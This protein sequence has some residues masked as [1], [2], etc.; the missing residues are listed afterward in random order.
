MEPFA[1]RRAEAMAATPQSTG[2]LAGKVAIVTGAASGIGLATLERFIAEGARVVFCDL[3]P[4]QGREMEG[5]IGAVASRLHHRRREEGG[6][7]D[8]YAIAARLGPATHFMPS[9][10]ADPKSLAA[11][12]DYAR[13][14]FGG[15][16]ILVNNAGVGGF[17]GSVEACSEEIFDRT[18]AVNLRA[19]WMAMKLAFPLLR[20]R[21]GGSIITTSSISALLGMPGQGAYGASK[22]AI[23]QL[24]RV[25]AMEGAKDFIRVNAVCPG[26]ILTPIIYDTPLLDRATDKALV[27]DALAKA[28]PIPR[29]GL[30]EDI[31][32]AIL[33]LASDES[34][35]VTG[36]AIA[37]DGGL[38]V[39]FGSQYR[40]K[41]AKKE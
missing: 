27:A 22:A 39:E 17:E 33:W 28:Q 38:S 11:V 34:S 20:E 26:G 16:D 9:D 10:V 13:Q 24:T 6:P 37:I 32:N 4:V 41:P 31:A 12:I 2:R 14:Q 36:Q 25:A 19:P 29:A 23:L 30:P 3:A 8:G 1:W 7:N 21:G 5:R 40:P 18:M 35:F 15:L